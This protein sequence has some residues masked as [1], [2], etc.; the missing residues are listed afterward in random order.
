M[1]Y[2]SSEGKGLMC[3]WALDLKPCSI[4]DVGAGSGTYADL[5]QAKLQ[6]CVFRAIEI[7]EPYIERFGLLAKYKDIVLDDVRNWSVDCVYNEFTAADVVI[8]GDVLEHLS[9]EDALAVWSTARA[10][11]RKAVLLSLPIVEYPQGAVDGNE[12]E[13][14]LHTWS[15]EAVLAELDGIVDWW[16][17][18]QIGVYRATGRAS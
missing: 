17:G 1:P 5:L 11:A 8:L 15:H 9:H 14:H 7:H 4:I 10:V 13:A 16:T 18:S 6:D 2:S 12:H 3:G